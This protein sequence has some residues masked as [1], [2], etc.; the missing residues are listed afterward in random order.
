MDEQS[1]LTVNTSVDFVLFQLL[2]HSVPGRAW[3]V[4]SDVIGEP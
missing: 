4:P 1:V 2:V 3:Y